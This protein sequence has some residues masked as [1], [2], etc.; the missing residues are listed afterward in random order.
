MPAIFCSGIWCSCN[1]A[2]NPP[3]YVEATWVK[4]VADSPVYLTGKIRSDKQN[5]LFCSYFTADAGVNVQSVI[6]KLDSGGNLQW[7][8]QIDSLTIFDFIVVHDSE[9]IVAASEKTTVTLIGIS[10]KGDIT[11]TAAFALPDVGATIKQVER[12]KIFLAES[13]AYNL[14]GTVNI[15]STDFASVGFMMEVLSSG[16]INWSQSYKFHQDGKSATFITGCSETA[17]GY[18]LFGNVQNNVPLTS[19]FFVMKCNATGDLLWTKFYATSTYD[20]MTMV[21][22]GYFCS[23]SDILASDD[24]NF[25]ACA[26]NVSYNTPGQNPSSINTTDDNSA[27]VFKINAEG[28]TLKSVRIRFGVQN[29]VADFVKRKDGGLLIGLNPFHLANFSLVGERHAF[30]ALISSELVLQN[31]TTIQTQYT[32]YMGSVCVMDDNHYA[33]QSMIQGFGKEHYFLE[34]IKTDENANF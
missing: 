7:R 17:D 30:T 18:M 22:N 10:A 9:I 11:F 6:I 20:E 25:F 1:K 24:G 27:R 21:Y 23:T 13:G 5:N 26:Y 33:I 14:S 28:D 3:N 34:V 32:D 19:S 16:I 31:I 29:E 2:E 15:Y 4:M 8:K 12:M